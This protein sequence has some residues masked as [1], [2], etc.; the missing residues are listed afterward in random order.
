[1]ER[2]GYKLDLGVHLFCNGFRGPLEEICTRTGIPKA[3]EWIPVT[4]SYLQVGDH[5]QKYSRRSMVAATP[6]EKQEKFEQLF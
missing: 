4:K 2:D 6:P 3:I 1:M 5:V